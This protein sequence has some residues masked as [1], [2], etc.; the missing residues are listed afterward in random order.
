MPQVSDEATLLATQVHALLADLDPARWRADTAAAVRQRGA[1]IEERIAS[2]IAGMRASAHSSR[3]P[4]VDWAG[5]LHRLREAWPDESRTVAVRE[6]WMTFRMRMEP[7]YGELATQLRAARIHVPILRPTNYARNVFHLSSALT[8]LLTVELLPAWT[9]PVA[10]AFA[11]AA[12]SMEILRRTRPQLNATLMRAFGPVAHP[13]ETYRVNSAT[14]YA[15]ALIILGWTHA[16]IPCALAVTVLGVGDPIA[17]IVGRRVGRTKLV[18]GRSLEGS[19]A[20]FVA[21]TIVTG[22]IGLTL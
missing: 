9:L 10:T 8:A 16:T 14:W 12:W 3:I 18:H 22:S 7:A 20:F 19:L 1:E 2:M 11:L 13:H 4:H 6:R 21:A 15:T 5:F 17:A